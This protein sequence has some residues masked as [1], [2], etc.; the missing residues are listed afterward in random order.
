M[1]Q[2]SDIPRGGWID[3]MAPAPV[4]PYL[5]LM[6]LDRPIGAWLLLIPC[7]WGAA[8]AAPKGGMGGWPDWKLLALFAVGAAVM[9]GSGC[10]FNDIVDRK[11]D[12]QVARTADRPVAS[13]A[14][15]VWAAVFF[16]VAQ[17]LV[18]LAVL[19]CLNATAIKWG[20]ASLVL[21]VAYPF[22]KRFIWWPQFVLGLAFNWGA[23]LGYVAVTGRLEAP[24]VWLYLAGIAWTLG[25]DTIYAHQDKEDDALVGV[26]SSALWLG[27]LLTQPFLGLIY[28]LAI[29][30]LFIAGKSAGLGWPY[31]VLLA[32]AAAHFIWQAL[33]VET[34][35]PQDCL[36]KF[37]SNRDVGLLIF[38]AI[39]AGQLWR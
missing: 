22:M 33:K 24:S 18:G 21:V 25:Y 6:R 29:L 34:D 5:R 9:R 16:M 2:A 27:E 19:L 4:R 35:D 10:T 36:S 17:A 20:L 26:K 14:V 1:T 32:L 12:R 15:G 37:R 38:A 7:W 8:L 3:R 39:V 23:L 28:M 11:I 31:Y 13:G 30:F